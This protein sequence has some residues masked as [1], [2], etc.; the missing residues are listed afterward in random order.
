MI[1]LMG[2]TQKRVLEF[3]QKNV[4]EQK[5]EHVEGMLV[6]NPMLMSVCGIT[7]YAAIL[8]KVLQDVEDTEGALT[9]YTRITCFIVMVC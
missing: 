1:E 2:L 6:K 7:F 3:I 5:R 9:T 4:P 8:C